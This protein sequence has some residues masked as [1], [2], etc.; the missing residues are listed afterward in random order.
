MYYIIFISVAYGPILQRDRGKQLWSLS[1]KSCSTET[2]SSW[3]FPCARPAI[4]VHG[5]PVGRSWRMRSY[6]YLTALA[7]KG[8]CSLLSAFD[9]K[10]ILW[11]FVANISSITLP[12]QMAIDYHFCQWMQSW[13]CVMHCFHSS[14]RLTCTEKCLLDIGR[15]F[16]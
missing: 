4:P 12:I 2:S 7:R 9:A 15:S 10:E 11:D 8:I 5:H 3:Q 14:V 1:L 16:I 6:I 13:V